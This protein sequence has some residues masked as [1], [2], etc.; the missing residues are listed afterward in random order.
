MAD[1]FPDYGKHDALGLAALVSRRE[2]TSAE[3]LETAIQRIERINPRINA[4]TLK[5]YDRARAAIAKGLPQGPFTGVPF[6]L[7]DLGQM[8]RASASPAAA[9]FS[10]TTFRRKTAR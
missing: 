6:L 1:P 2:V 4:L 7:K 9:A 3:L 10:P 5:L 8:L